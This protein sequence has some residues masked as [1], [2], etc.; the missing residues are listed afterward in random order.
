M[1][2]FLTFTVL[3][4]VLGAV[5]AIAASGLVL[6]YNTSGI[7]N[8]AHGAQAM[9]GAFGFYQLQVV[10]GLPTPLA[11][12]IMLGLIGPAI[13]LLLYLGIMRGLRDTEQVTKIVVTVAILLAFVS[14]SQW[15][16]DPQEARGAQPFFGK[17]SGFDVLGVPLRY[18]ELICIGCAV[19]IAVGLRFL[20]VK[21]R[22]GVLMRASVDDPDL[23]RLGGHDPDRV[24]MIAWVLGSTL[25][26]L[27]GILIAPVVG[28]SLEANALT[29]LV[30][31]AFAA[32]L[33]GRLKSIPMTYVGAIVLGLV[34]TYLVGYAPS[35]WAWV[36]NLRTAL[37]MV[38]LFVVLLLLPQERLRGAAV[39]SRERY[40][41]PPVRRAA[42]W[43]LGFVAI[44]VLFRQIIEDAAVGTL[45][46]GISFAI[47]ALSLTLLTGYA[48]EM[49]LAPLA[50]GAVATVVAFHTGIEGSGVDARM[51][52]LGVLLGVLAAAATGA[53]VAL[54]ALRLRG[55][56][57]A[58]ATLA[59]GVFVSA[60]LLR[61]TTPHTLFG[62]TFTIFPNGS[63]IV[64]GLQVGPLDLHDRDT[65][66]VTLTAVFGLLGV[67][68]IALRN[69]GYGR[70]LAAMKDSP[71]ASAMLGQRLVRL[72]LSV[73]ALSTAIAGLGGIFMS[74]ALTT[75]SKDTFVFVIGLSLVM[76]TVVGG[77]G[78]VSGAL[79]GG[80]VSGAGLAASVGILGDLAI[81]H[82][83]HAS[84]LGILSHL[85]LLS[86]A[87]VGVGVARDPSGALR[88]I[89][90][91]H[92]LLAK[93]P[94]VRY[95]ALVV[96]SGLY[97]LAW[98]DLLPTSLFVVLSMVLWMA[99]P[100]VGLSVRREKILGA[101]APKRVTPPELIGIDADYPANIA[102]QL[103]KQLGIDLASAAEPR[104]AKRPDAP[105]VRQE[106]SDVLA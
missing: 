30:I 71:A 12:V 34:G 2:T 53:L 1:T 45:L 35:E 23:L 54:P 80:I 84:S 72:K 74:M 25:A 37:P 24:S 29:L 17:G 15:I 105:A 42:V 51:N 6:T 4:L 56:Y 61:D 100:A 75:V 76:L 67:G 33:F 66:L 68:V 46:V 36:G 92:R 85:V 32:A 20:F 64:P 13:G 104:R 55:L 19:V 94:E 7:F 82:P 70:R 62:K 27:A 31:D 101:D 73:F 14:L 96:Q 48:G 98:L 95:A 60:M 41:V 81:A 91:G 69:S 5:Y 89:F 39:R 10:W 63:L 22:L 86:V 65:F 8:F 49:N 26:V 11:L 58:L 78:Y 18:H 52:L 28:G 88:E 79:F 3:G 57:L 50:F 93:A 102:E 103:D 16:W 40:E 99:L 43:A 106:V 90:A 47:I 38:I 83:E 21:S 59:F 97:L 87:M 9:V 77:I 44:I